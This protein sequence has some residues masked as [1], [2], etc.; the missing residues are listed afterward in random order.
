LLSGLGYARR[1]PGPI[2]GSDIRPPIDDT[3]GA[4]SGARVVILL[5][6]FWVPAMIA[7]A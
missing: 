2:R 7:D 4:D 6:V 3:S 5:L 1:F